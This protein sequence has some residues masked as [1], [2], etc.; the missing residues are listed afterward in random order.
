MI[1]NHY[2]GIY[3]FL[4]GW[5][6]QCGDRVRRKTKRGPQWTFLV[7]Q[8]TQRYCPSQYPEWL[9]RTTWTQEYPKAGFMKKMDRPLEM[10]H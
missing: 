2:L 6:E 1:N 5:E 4:V 8:S 3:I 7:L 10:S 9:T